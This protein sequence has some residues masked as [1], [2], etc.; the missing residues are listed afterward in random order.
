MKTYIQSAI[1]CVALAFIA[2]ASFAQSRSTIVNG[3]VV[4]D[5]DNSPLPGVN[6]TIAGTVVGMLTDADGKFS[7]PTGLKQ[8]DELVF[9]FVGYVTQ[10]YLVTEEASQDVTIRMKDDNILI[11]EI[12]S[13]D[14]YTVKSRRGILAVLKGKH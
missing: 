2:Q 4:I 14:H 10:K 3:T 6:V 13:N 8:G 9:S 11:E 7:F 1:V 12:A 5:Q